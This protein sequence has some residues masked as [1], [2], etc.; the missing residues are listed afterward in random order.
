MGRAHQEDQA[1]DQYGARVEAQGQ[2][3]QHE[4]AEVAV[5]DAVIDPLAVVVKVLGERERG[6]AP[7]T[8][9]L[10]QA[11]MPPNLR[12]YL[13]HPLSHLPLAPLSGFHS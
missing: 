9:P 8:Q 11:P 12:F 1:G 3:K 6:Q 4:E 10:T 7:R 13:P 2:D 5:T